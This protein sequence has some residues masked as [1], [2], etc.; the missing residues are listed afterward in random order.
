M[1]VLG[2][3]LIVILSAVE[4]GCLIIMTIRTRNYLRERSEQRT[5]ARRAASRPRAYQMVRDSWAVYRNRRS[6]WNSIQK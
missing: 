1:V 3:V 2:I 5:A 4:A 6:L